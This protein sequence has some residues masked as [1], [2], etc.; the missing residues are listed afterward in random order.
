[1][2]DGGRKFQCRLKR[3]TSP[4]PI[5]RMKQRMG[6]R[7]RL[8]LSVSRQPFHCE[9]CQ[10][11][12][13]SETQLKQVNASSN[14]R[15]GQ[16]SLGCFLDSA[17]FYVYFQHINSRRHRECLAGKSFRV[18]FTPYNKLHPSATL[19]VSCIANIHTYTQ[20]T[21]PC[22]SSFVRTVI[23]HPITQTILT[24][25]TSNLNFNTKSKS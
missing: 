10:V 5:C 13:N 24:Y 9:T 20:H 3:K 23:I 17:R 7:F 25:P 22:T 19:A 21:K 4:K 2:L 15:K 11:S 18:K 12:V 14:K 1:M 16:H 8:G 6:G